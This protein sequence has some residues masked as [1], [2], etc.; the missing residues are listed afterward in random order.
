MTS[1][2]NA[3]ARTSAALV[4]TLP[5][6]LLASLVLCRFLPL[7]EDRRFAIGFLLAVP[8]WITGICTVAL[9]RSGAFAWLAC[10]IVGALLG[11]LVLA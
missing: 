5:D 2:W 6:A 3:A 4:G 8:L 11:L 9:A 7:R 1:R 10:A